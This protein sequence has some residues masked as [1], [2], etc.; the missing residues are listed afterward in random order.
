MRDK[1]KNFRALRRSALILAAAIAVV[2]AVVLLS[3]GAG[4]AG[5]VAD[6]AEAA[7]SP[8]QRAVDSALDWLGNIY[9]YLYK[10]DDLA[11]ENAELKKEL[12]DAQ[13]Q[14]RQGQAAVD[15]NNRFRTL[16]HFS[17]RHTD[18]IYEPANITEWTPS[19]W[20]SSFVIS[21]GSDDG[22]EVGDCVIT[23]EGYLCGQVAELGGAWARVRTVIDVNT[24]VGV[25]V[26]EGGNAAMAVGDFALMNQGRVKLTY[27]T[28]GTQLVPGDTILTSGGGERFPPGLVVGTIEEVRQAAGGQTF[29]GVV[30]PACDFGTLSQVFVIKSFDTVE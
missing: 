26:G 13:E 12:A 2:V 6:S 25:L 9:G 29:F 28:A 16:F 8:V 4:R 30:K 11:A 20:S 24:A 7:A 23:A 1:K 18:F 10:Y 22:L 15:E 14:A 27:L 21:K 19:N 17:Q 3:G 5:V